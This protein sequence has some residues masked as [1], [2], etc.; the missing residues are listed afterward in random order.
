MKVK[1]DLKEYA[2]LLCYQYLVMELV[3][4]NDKKDIPK[5]TLAKILPKLDPLI[6]KTMKEVLKNY[7]PKWVSLLK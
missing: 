4:I 5:N 2:T 3:K 7:T 1:L 6:E